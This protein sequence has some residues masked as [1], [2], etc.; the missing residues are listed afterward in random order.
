MPWRAP[1]KRGIAAAD[2]Q[3][4]F[5][6]ALVTP[7]LTAHPTEVRRMSSIAREVEIA[8][9]LAERDRML[10]TPGEEQ[11]REEALRATMLTLWQTYILRRNRPRV[12][13]EVSNALLVLRDDILADAAATL[14]GARGPAARRRSVTRATLPSFFRLGS[15]IGGD[16]DG[17][18]FVTASV[19]REALRSPQPPRFEFPVCRSSTRWLESFRSI[20]GWSA[21]PTSSFNWRKAS[22]INPS[23][24]LRSH[25][26]APSRR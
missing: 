6:T 7:V 20:Q 10:A 5:A 25:T 18:P 13:D 17:N 16:R 4:F 3:R 22:T 2:L 26:G 1:A 9:H 19:L 11:A 8:R 23:I 24:A 14:C 15:W 21:P 12:I